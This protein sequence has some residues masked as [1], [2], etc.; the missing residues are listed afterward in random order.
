MEWE[1]LNL[2]WICFRVFNG[3]TPEKKYSAKCK[4]KE[5]ESNLYKKTGKTSREKRAGRKYITKQTDREKDIL[6]PLLLSL[7]NFWSKK[8]VVS[9]L[10]KQTQS[11]CS[12]FCLIKFLHFSFMKFLLFLRSRIKMRSLNKYM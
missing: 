6:C 2:R 7:Q 4:Q 3:S 10:H 11:C 1:Y 5:Q 12:V 8:V 9:Q